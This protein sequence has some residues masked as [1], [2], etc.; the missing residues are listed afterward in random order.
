MKDRHTKRLHLDQGYPGQISSSRILQRSGVSRHRR[1]LCN[2][3]AGRWPGH[4]CFGQGHLPK[5]AKRLLTPLLGH[6]RGRQ[7]IRR[8][9]FLC[10]SRGSRNRAPEDLR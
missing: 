2:A 8:R 9:G 7:R 10:V 1:H 6:P 5:Q 4:M 3:A